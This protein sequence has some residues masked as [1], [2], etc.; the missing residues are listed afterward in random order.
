MH[1][2]I[3]GMNQFYREEFGWL[4]LFFLGSLVLCYGLK[5]GRVGIK[6]ATFYRK[7]DPSS[8]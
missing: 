6:G 8:F 4:A 5:T 2:S 7:D 1:L 3:L